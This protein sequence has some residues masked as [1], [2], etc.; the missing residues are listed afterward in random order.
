[1]KAAWMSF[2][3][4]HEVRPGLMCIDWLKKHD[5]EFGL[6][7]TGWLA[8]QAPAL[9]NTQQMHE[10]AK[11]AEQPTAA[12]ELDGKPKH[13]ARINVQSGPV[14]THSLLV[15]V[16]IHFTSCKK[17][18]PTNQTSL[19]LCLETS[20][21]KIS[22]PSW[23]PVPPAVDSPPPPL[24]ADGITPRS[25]RIQSTHQRVPW[26]TLL[27]FII[28]WITLSIS[29]LLFPPPVYES[30]SFP[31]TSLFKFY[32]MRLARGSKSN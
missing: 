15:F 27:W 26:L 16:C 14:C 13:K 28:N 20:S 1:M 5:S 8:W 21:D 31:S 6:Q 18:H 23:A 29:T 25:R 22:S 32:F 12:R 7:L 19:H 24:A 11:P 3:T 9:V 17:S 30:M 4:D 10:R 2:Q